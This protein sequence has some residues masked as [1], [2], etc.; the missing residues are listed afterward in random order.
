MGKQFVFQHFRAWYLRMLEHQGFPI[1]VLVCVAVITGTALWTDRHG[2]AAVLP[3]PTAA[4]DVSAAQLQQQLLRDALSATATP[5]VEPQ[6]WFSPLEGEILL[7]F[8]S[9]RMVRSDATG[10]WAIHDAVDIAAPE[11]SAIRAIADGVVLDAGQDSLLGTW[12]LVDHKEGIQALYAGLQLT[13]SYLPGDS[14][15]GGDVI[16]FCGNVM[17]A[18]HPSGP[19][20]HLRITQN[21]VPIDPHTLWQSETV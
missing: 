2:E 18:E 19:H 13:A 1:V 15:R 17:L 4:Y 16:G 7:S 10:I 21:G 5:T 9:E 12:L 14:M 20:L 3:T 8:D 11:G 6:R